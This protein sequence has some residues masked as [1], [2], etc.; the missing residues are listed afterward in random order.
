[1]VLSSHGGG[2]QIVYLISLYWLMYKK[3]L[4]IAPLSGQ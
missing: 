3:G 4:L 1:M 2:K